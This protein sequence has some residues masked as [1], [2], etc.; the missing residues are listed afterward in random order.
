MG[1]VGRFRSTTGF[2]RGTQTVCRTP[3]GLELGE[4]MGPVQSGAADGDLIRRTTSQDQLLAERL[5]RNAD[6]A[7]AACQELLAELSAP[8]TLLDVE[9]MFDGQGLY[10]Y[11]IGDVPSE[12]DSMTAELAEAYEAHA[13]IARFSETL[14]AGCGPEC[15]TEEAGCS[16]GNCG[17]C[18]VAEA[19]RTPA[20]PP[21]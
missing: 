4:V 5:R 14:E 3:R 7:F 9:L 12:V 11:F 21:S 16:S 17:S 10:F 1:N 8:P 6:D 15:G 18:A 13:Q 20:A 2:A 19:C